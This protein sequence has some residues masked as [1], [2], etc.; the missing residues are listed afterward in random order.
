MGIAWPAALPQC[1]L[2]YDGG[3]TLGTN[4]VDF[5]PDVAT[6]P[7]R[8]QRST[9]VVDSVSM[10]FSMTREQLAT[11]KAWF[12]TDLKSGALPFQ[13]DTGDGPADHYI[14]GSPAINRSAGNSW[15]ISF[16]TRRV[17]L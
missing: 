4:Y 3:E 5:A 7:M 14:E 17:M 12:R 13:L 1:P 16:S 8:R 9:L 15:L 10:V 11:F 6:L 2:P